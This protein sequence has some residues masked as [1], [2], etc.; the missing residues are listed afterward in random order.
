VTDVTTGTYQ[1]N[2]TTAMPDANFTAI[3]TANNGGVTA[4]TSAAGTAL[5]GASTFANASSSVYVLTFANDAGSTFKDVT[6]VNV[7]VMG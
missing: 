1:V 6:Y 3:A 2:F 5:Y 7:I 4:G